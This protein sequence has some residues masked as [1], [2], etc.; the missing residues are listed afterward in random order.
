M[1]FIG[2]NCNNK[3]IIN[4]NIKNEFLFRSILHGVCGCC[5]DND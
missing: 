2:E 3:I 1:K 5:I 4:N